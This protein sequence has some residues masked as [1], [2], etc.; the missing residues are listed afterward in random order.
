MRGVLVSLVAVFAALDV[1][2]LWHVYLASLLFGLVDAFFQPAYTTLVPQVAPA[3]VLLGA[4]SLTGL[5]QQLGW[6]AGPAM[7]AAVVSL[8]GTLAAFAINGLSFFLS[9]ACLVP[10]LSL[11][12]QVVASP[13]TT[14]VLQRI[15][16]AIG[17]VF[18]TP[19]LWITITVSALT[20]VMLTGP[21]SVAL[22]FLVK[23]SLHADLGVL[24]LLYAMFPLGYVLAELW[25]GSARRL[26][27]QGIPGYS[28]LLLAGGMILM[29]GLP[30]P[31]IALALA[32]LVNGAGL[33]VYSLIWTNTLQ[34]MVPGEK[35]GRVASV[36][37]L[38]SFGLLP[39]GYALTGWATDQLG[40]PLVFMIG[41]GVTVV[42]AA[43][44]LVHPAIRDLD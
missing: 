22:P 5:S 26:R 14:D 37:L 35:L 34:E 8:G 7:G 9:A 1:L 25:T 6:V 29:L 40:P 31:L 12:Q 32:A 19:W 16:E 23:D 36:D 38:G 21:Y 20:N 41:G 11:T 44:A 18:G 4:N 24:G 33:E 3:D 43:L 28:G 39:I 27:H 30:L 42:V 2:A 15:R 13:H 17:F 10:L